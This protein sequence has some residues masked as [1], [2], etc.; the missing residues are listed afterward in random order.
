MKWLSIFEACSGEFLG[1]RYAPL[2]SLKANMLK[3]MKSFP[4]D[5]IN[6]LFMLMDYDK[7]EIVEEENFV[8][9]MTPWAAFSACDINN[10]NCLETHEMEKLFWLAEDKR[11][12]ISKVQ[13]EMKLIDESGDGTIS[14]DEWIMYLITPDPDSGMDCYDLK[15][16]G[17]FDKF[18]EDKNGKIDRREMSTFM[19]DY[20]KD[21]LIML[22]DVEK[23]QLRVKYF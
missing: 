11:P 5:V 13:K 6:K 3:E 8:A 12:P 2:Q 15:I 14:R 10:D 4:Q 7:V 1:T 21:E 20:F 19:M 22:D 18:D 9:V 17:L 16:R 23:E